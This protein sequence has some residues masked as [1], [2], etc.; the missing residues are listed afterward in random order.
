MQA[1]VVRQLLPGTSC[2]F[3]EVQLHRS[4]HYLEHVYGMVVLCALGCSSII[5]FVKLKGH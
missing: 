5:A 4:H 2:H 3:G 1:R